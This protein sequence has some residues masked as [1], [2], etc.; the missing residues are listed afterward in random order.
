MIILKCYYHI[1]A[2][3]KKI[4]YKII[5]GKHVKFGKKVTFRKG[6]SLVI[7]ND[8]TVEISDGCFFN[9]Y[10]SI[11]AKEKITI[12]QN[13]IFGEN[14]KIYDHNHVFKNKNEIIKN[15]GFKTEKVEIEKN[16]W[17]ASNVIILKGV[18]I[19]ENSVVGAG[20]VVEKN[21]DSDK[22]VKLTE[23]NYKIENIKYKGNLL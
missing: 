8:A 21:V 4:F 14:V 15:Q 13:C 12:G 10:C 1:I 19:G 22:I 11:N 20:C 3:I 7:E 16:C 9:N 18:K 6:F 5:Y 23:S 17:I 2:I